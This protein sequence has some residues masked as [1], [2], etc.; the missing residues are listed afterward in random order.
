MLTGQQKLPNEFTTELRCI[1]FCPIH[2][3]FN[4]ILQKIALLKFQTLILQFSLNCTA[5][6]SFLGQRFFDVNRALDLRLWRNSNSKREFD[7]KT[8]KR[9]LYT[10]APICAKA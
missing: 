10:H 1:L 6:K 7:A 9:F 8:D 3:A 4:L 2:R 5:C